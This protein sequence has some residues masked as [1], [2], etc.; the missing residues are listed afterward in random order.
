MDVEFIK[1]G[2]P[3][4]MVTTFAGYVGAATG[5]RS[6][7]F[8]VSVNEREMTG[9]LPIPNLLKGVL[10]LISAILTTDAYPVTWATRRLLRT[11]HQRSTL[12]S[13]C[14]ANAR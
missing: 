8:S 5:M 13:K 10:N 1:G 11:M 2:E 7:V 14:S 3:A 6:G 12:L 9:P 4:F